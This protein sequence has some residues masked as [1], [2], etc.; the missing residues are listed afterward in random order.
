MRNF[1]PLSEINLLFTE[2]LSHAI[3]Y[4]IIFRENALPNY[5]YLIIFKRKDYSKYVK[6]IKHEI[7]WYSAMGWDKNVIP[8]HNKSGKLEH[9]FTTYNIKLKKRIRVTL[10]AE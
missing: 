8:I 2:M 6:E 10:K 3:S 5:S 4:E 7:G 9:T 1:E